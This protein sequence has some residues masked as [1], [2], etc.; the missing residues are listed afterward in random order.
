MKGLQSHSA[1]SLTTM[2]SRSI[3]WEDNA[4][5]NH[6]SKCPPIEGQHPGAA[7]IIISGAR[8][9]L[10]WSC[11]GTDR[12]LSKEFVVAGPA[13]LDVRLGMNCPGER[14][15]TTCLWFNLFIAQEGWALSCQL[16]MASFETE[17]QDCHAACHRLQYTGTPSSQETAFKCVRQ[18]NT[19]FSKS[20][21]LGRL[22]WFFFFYF[23][24]F[25]FW[26]WPKEILETF[27]WLL[28]DRQ[29]NHQVALRC[30]SRAKNQRNSSTHKWQ[31]LYFISVASKQ[32]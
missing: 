10:R 19:G 7:V 22:Y 5:S 8:E 11:D 24:I 32:L 1:T 26:I 25:S 16:T 18:F 3:P 31:F 9:T 23:S 21:I 29:K 17:Q 6:F 30:F 14:A 20:G 13:C 15:Q 4:I 2:T 12:P 28:T 27:P